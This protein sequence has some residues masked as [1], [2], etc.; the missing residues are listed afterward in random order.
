MNN[1]TTTVKLW[2]EITEIQSEHLNGGH[3]YSYISLNIGGGVGS[4]QVNGGDGS[5]INI[6]PSGKAPSYGY[7]GYGYRRYH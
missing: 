7:Y 4:V 5:Q 6:L 2:N 3:G 1:N